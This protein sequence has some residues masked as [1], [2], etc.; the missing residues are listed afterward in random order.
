[1]PA[2]A[3][4]VITDWSQA[5]AATAAYIDSVKAQILALQ[6]S[7]LSGAALRSSSVGLAASGSA[8]AQTGLSSGALSAEQAA[9]VAAASARLQAIAAVGPTSTAQIADVEAQRLV[10]EREALRLASVGAAAQG[11]TTDAQV[12]LGDAIKAQAEQAIALTA[13]TD[14]QIAL[15]ATNNAERAAYATRV[16]EAEAET[17]L[18]QEQVAKSILVQSQ[19]GAALV[20][21][22]D[23]QVTLAAEANA[24]RAI[25]EA[26]VTAAE[27]ETV[28]AQQRVAK[29]LELQAQKAVVLASLTDEQ[30]ATQAQTRSLLAA[31]QTRLKAASPAGAAGAVGSVEAQTVTVSAD[32]KVAAAVTAQAEKAA[33]LTNLTSEQVALVADSNKQLAEYNAR[34]ALAQAQ[35]SSGQATLTQRALAY[36]RGSPDATTQPGAGQFFAGRAI[37]S[38]AYAASALVIYGAYEELRKSFDE[39]TKLQVTMALV[40][41]EFQALGQS[42]QFPQMVQAIQQISRE[43]GLAG[44]EVAQV[45]LQEKGV[46][47]DTAQSINETAAAMQY[48][49]VTGQDVAQAINDLTA[50]TTTWKISNQQASD[51]TQVLQDRTGVMAKE[52]LNGVGIVAP[53]A[54][55]L[56]L[57]FQQTAG[58]IAAASQASGRDAPAI[59]ENFN[60]ILPA[61][62]KSASQLVAIFQT[63]PAVSGDAAKLSADLGGGNY[64]GAL[65]ILIK[66]WSSLTAAQQ[67]NT[68]ELVGGR[69]EANALA[70]VLENPAKTLNL[71]NGN[72][73][74]TG[75]TTERFQKQMASLRGEM[76]QFHTTLVTIGQD[77][78][79][80][81]LGLA[82]ASMIS[83]LTDAA[84]FAEVLVRSFDDLDKATGGLLTQLV[85][86]VT[87]LKTLQLLGKLSI[88]G[89]AASA[90]GGGLLGRVGLA[91]TGGG[92]LGKVGLGATP[93]A[94]DAASGAPL[95]AETAGGAGLGAALSGG[96]KSLVGKLAGGASTLGDATLGA[97]GISDLGIAAGAA[98][99]ATGVGVAALAI[100]LLVAF[101][102]QRKANAQATADFKKGLAGLS[103]AEIARQIQEIKTGTPGPGDTRYVPA[104]GDANTTNLSSNF[105]NLILEQ[106]KRRLVGQGND[107]QTLLGASFMKPEDVDQLNKALADA[108]AGTLT[109]SEY[110]SA[111]ST[112]S[113]VEKNPLAQDALKQAALLVTEQS[114]VYK[115]LNDSTGL[116]LQDLSDLATAYSDGSIN[117]AGYLD[118]LNKQVALL[119]SQVSSG[120]TDAATMKLLAAASKARTDFL[121]TLAKG[122]TDLAIQIDKL[123]GGGP[124]SEALIDVTAISTP[125]IDAATKLTFAKAALTAEQSAFNE[126]LSHAKTAADIRALL[127]T[128]FAID[129]TV[130]AAILSAQVQGNTGYD[131]LLASVTNPAGA[132]AVDA[133]LGLA[134]GEDVS[135]RIDAVS[136]D[137]VKNHESVKQALTKAFQ[138]QEV[139]DEA[140][141][142]LLKHIHDYEDVASLE[143]DLAT[144]QGDLATLSSL[145]DFSA[146]TTGKPDPATYAATM[147]QAIQKTAA[148]N[149]AWYDALKQA[150]SLNPGKVAADA[151][152]EA[153]QAVADAKSQ[154]AYGAD[155]SVL[156]N[157]QAAL[158]KANQDQAKAL[159]DR[160]TAH[161]SL[162]EAQAKASGNTLEA[163]QLAVQ[164]AQYALAAYQS[165]GG[166]DQGVIDK[167]NT[168]ITNAYAAEQQVIQANLD[169]HF[170]LLQAQ[171]TASGDTIGA[172]RDSLLKAQS[173]LAAY[174]AKGGTDQGEL[175]KLNT[176]VVSAAASVRDA[177]LSTDTNK[178]DVA[179]QLERITAAQ[180]IAQFEALL[181]IP[182]LTADQTNQILLKIQQ[183]RNS[184]GQ[185][186]QFDIPTDINLPTLYEVRRSL[187]DQQAGVGYQDNR[188]AYINMT[189][190]TGMDQA[191]AT[192]FLSDAMGLPVQVSGSAPR[193]Y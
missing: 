27:A 160:Q 64:G 169:A 129:P 29:T 149:K 1:M 23:E 178:I 172:A 55:E 32:Q 184:L 78:I 61:M 104:A 190:A 50:V 183:L 94:A 80:G 136:A 65:Q 81:P 123:Q 34:V 162:L 57:S 20:A 105:K 101:N 11:A 131:S 179:L 116:G 86:L 138:A 165:Q 83:F 176:A 135:V 73:N 24:N 166:T 37:S 174:K 171:A 148:D 115:A 90:A 181:K 69:R 118:A 128:G 84:K 52:I 191:A 43:T 48:I 99:L 22:T 66:D 36:S 153:N 120:L 163:A 91:A 145:P 79:S 103:D 126:A 97:F 39:A 2:F 93:L 141:I 35:L 63:I 144:I 177:T 21:T 189:V 76:L 157:A 25:Y 133:A 14:E 8:V 4:E 146:T 42:S 152:A 96:A 168:D 132:A 68:L 142:K 56:G 107:I 173:D 58:L 67:A 186:L 150:D 187:Q 41:G 188:N 88:F 124:A 106:S 13:L 111:E 9:S 46:W 31:Y 82:F 28:A 140:A 16:T 127:D 130:S 7:G 75:T 40:Q 71:M 159:E 121:S 98:S 113:R 151:V 59:A 30:I 185:D 170:G 112:L 110:S 10:A 72:L 147:L 139:I 70:A 38:A 12:A 119:Q 161:D 15:I 3:I 85:E 167:L 47:R 19:K 143:S 192:Q 164:H 117:A 154:V 51:V 175:D 74:A 44:S 122:N 77:I 33:A 87:V 5:K 45:A 102:N 100:G 182:N 17:V 49:K 114:T 92:V 89:G 156:T 158:T 137:A 6:A 54:A 125:G 62:Q 26:Q 53:V 180:A 108:A 134:G 18:A 95:L 193:K 155:P 60:R 109:Q